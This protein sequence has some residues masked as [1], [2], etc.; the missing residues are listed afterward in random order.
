MGGQKYPSFYGKRVGFIPHGLTEE[1]AT[2]SVYHDNGEYKYEVL[3]YGKTLRRCKCTKAIRE[4]T[5][6][7]VLPKE[8]DGL[9]VKELGWECMGA[10]FTEP[11]NRAWVRILQKHWIKEHDNSPV[12]CGSR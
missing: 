10:D 12:G 6:K 1:M 3:P 8:M 4:K 9:S 7:V 2:G 5:K 11:E